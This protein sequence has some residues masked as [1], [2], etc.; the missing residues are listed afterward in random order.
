VA[1]RP[2]KNLTEVWQAGFE[3]Q[4]EGSTFFVNVSRKSEVEV[5]K[6][7]DRLVYVIKGARAALRNNRNPLRTTF[8]AT[9]VS[10]ARLVQ[11]KDDVQ[12]V[13]KLKRP[14]SA[15]WAFAPAGELMQLR[16]SFR[17]E[18]AQPQPDDPDEA[19][20]TKEAEGG[21]RGEGAKDKKASEDTKAAEAPEEPDRN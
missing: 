18:K 20:K 8:F 6:G 1:P 11:V 7:E 9:P 12:L 14:A 21:E 19:E 4:P 16:I 2:K 5:K 10:V 15:T 17:D 3:A 13:L